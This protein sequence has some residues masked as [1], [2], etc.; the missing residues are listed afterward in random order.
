MKPPG[1]VQQVLTEDLRTA[2]EGPEGAEA[3]AEGAH[4]Q[5]HPPVD[6]LMLGQPGAVAAQQSRGV[7]FVNQEQGPVAVAD[8]H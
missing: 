3:L 5:G 8:L 7:G 4:D 1:G 2:D 6:P